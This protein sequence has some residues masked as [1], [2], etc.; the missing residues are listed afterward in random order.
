MQGFEKSLRVY[1]ARSMWREAPYVTANV[2]LWPQTEAL[3]GNLAEL[4]SLPTDQRA[5][6]SQ[7]VQAEIARSSDL[8]N[9]DQRLVPLLCASGT[10]FVDA[11]PTDIRALRSSFRPVYDALRTDR[12]SA[13]L[14]AQIERLKR[15]TSPG[16][17]LEIPA[18]CP[19]A[20]PS[21]SPTPTPRPTTRITRLDGAWVVSYSRAE[22][23]AAHPDPSEVTSDNIGTFYLTFERGNGSSAPARDATGPPHP[24]DWWYEVHGD[25]VTIHIDEGAGP[26]TWSYRWSV[27]GDSLTFQKLGGH[28]PDCSLLISEGRC[29]PTGFVVKP[30][31]RVS[32]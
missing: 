8:A 20:A 2:N 28:E 32:G 31:R 5:L 1:S 14:F 23:L 4:A 21:P 27:Y 29:E 7:A 22:L 25:T 3:I 6:L 26:A 12:A 18:R 16:P 17:P 11:S 30:F 9:G 13:P 15:A 24:P 19:T 10:R